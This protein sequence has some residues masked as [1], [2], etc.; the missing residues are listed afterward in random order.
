MVCWSMILLCYIITC[1][2]FCNKRFCH[3][4]GIICTRPCIF[5]INLI[6]NNALQV[7]LVP[8]N[9]KCNANSSLLYLVL[10]LSF[11]WFI[12]KCMCIHTQNILLIFFFWINYYLLDQKIRKVSIL[13]L[14]ISSPMFFLS[15]LYICFCSLSFSFLLK[16]I[17]RLVL[18]V[19]STHNK[20]PPFLFVWESSSLHFVR[21][22]L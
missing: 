2:W 10:L 7:V 17:L 12:R 21:T 9:K 4:K 19:R 8:Y 16:N 11:I 3:K 15:L 6:S 13:P 14:I 5:I 18:Q 22:V 20:F 1:L